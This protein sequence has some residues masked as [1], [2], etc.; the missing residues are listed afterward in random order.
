MSNGIINWFRFASPQTFYPLAGKLIPWFWALTAVFGLA[1][2]A[3]WRYGRK[4]DHA[5]TKWL[6]VALMFYPYAISRTWM[7][8]AVGVALCAAVLF[9]PV[10]MGKPRELR[11]S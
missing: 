2:L 6:G 1:G 11:D 10:L 3:A 4:T 5:P 7:L 9:Q 8:Y